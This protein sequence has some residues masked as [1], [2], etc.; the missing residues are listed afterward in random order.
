LVD[1]IAYK[2]HALQ[3]LQYIECNIQAIEDTCWLQNYLK[4]F[5]RANRSKAV[6][7]SFWLDEYAYFGIQI[8]DP[9]E[10]QD[11]ENWQH[12]SEASRIEA[13]MN[14]QILALLPDPAPRGFFGLKRLRP[15][16][17]TVT[18]AS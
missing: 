13:T 5:P 1:F 18:K 10:T 14:N 12:K 4:E 8:E 2:E 15:S 9:E 17:A 7:G 11:I 16:T 3:R 6:A